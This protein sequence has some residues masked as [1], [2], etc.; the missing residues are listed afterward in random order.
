MKKF[1]IKATVVVLPY[2]QL[3]TKDSLAIFLDN[4]TITDNTGS[5]NSD[6]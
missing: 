3:T 1:T 2:I 4:I 5:L 6:S